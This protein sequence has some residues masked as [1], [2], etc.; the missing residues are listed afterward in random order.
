MAEKKPSRLS[1]MV[2]VLKRTLLQMRRSFEDRNKHVGRLDQTG[3]SFPIAA[4]RRSVLF[5]EKD[6]AELRLELGKVQNLRIVAKSIN[7]AHVPAGETFSFWKQVGRCTFR[8]GFVT[9]R[10]IQEGCIMPALGGGICQLSNALYGVAQDAG[11]EIVERHSHSRQVPGMEAGRDATVAWNY[12]DLRFRSDQPFSI[13]AF[14]TTTELV[15]RIRKE[16][17]RARQELVLINQRTV[18]N[19]CATCG[20]AG[21][22]NWHRVDR[23]ELSGGVAWLLSQWSP[24]F[25]QV[26]SER[27]QLYRLIDGKRWRRPAYIFQEESFGSVHDFT[28]L[29]LKQAFRRRRVDERGALRQMRILYESEELARA[30]ARRLPYDVRHVVVSQTLLPFLWRE[31]ALGGRTFDVLMS[32][33]PLSVIHQR[34]DASASCHPER[35]LLTDF[36][37]PDDIVQAE[38][39]ALAASDRQFS[40]H[41]AV[42]GCVSRPVFLDWPKQKPMAWT[43]GRSIVYPGPTA[44]RKGAFE[45]REVARR[46]ELE[47]VLL[48][49]V[50]EG[51]DFWDGVKTSRMS[52]TDNWLSGV[53]MVV[54]PAVVEDRPIALLKAL[55]SGCPVV[56]TEACG[57][58]SQPGLTLVPVGDTEALMVAVARGLGSVP[59]HDLD[60]LR[61]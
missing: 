6:P 45:L 23:K 53:A 25:E 55:A 36:R 30:F 37:A 35:K 38:S 44:A 57:L 10:Q 49:N 9:G 8:R 15:V 17:V 26:D 11:L 60:S 4:E 43:P 61:C 16:R 46:L 18:A 58:R 12:V 52:R 29:G 33:L 19:S 22:H 51:Q 2:F 27:T 39:Q 32:R 54:Q 7:G 3:S 24:E 56:A 21:C 28:L 40:C 14:L 47:V 41:Q 50:L 13:E 1:G 42:A 20:Q 59:T 5:R 34:L 31:G 48:D